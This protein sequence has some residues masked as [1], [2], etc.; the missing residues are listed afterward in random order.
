MKKQNSHIKTNNFYLKNLKYNLFWETTL[1]CNAK[2]KHYGS[3]AGESINLDEE[4][5]TQEIR[6]TFNN[7][8]K[9]Y[10]VNQILINITG[11]KPLL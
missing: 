2:C 8:A 10:N 3:K 7:I 9:Q 4:L 5:T 1:R 11:G 6:D